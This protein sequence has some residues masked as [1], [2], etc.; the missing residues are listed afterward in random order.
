[1]KKAKGKTPGEWPIVIKRGS[2]TA[3][4]FRTPENGRDRFTVEWYE[5]PARKRLTRVDLAEAR[6]EAK[7]IADTLNAGRG[8]ALELSGADRDAY[9]AAVR[10]LKPLDVPLNVAIAEYVKA[11][12]YNV[13][14]VEAAK[15]Y[16]ESHNA[17]LPD[18]TIEEVYQEMLKAK[19][20]DGASE[21]YLHDLKT[22]LGHFSRDFKDSLANVTTADL[23]AWLRKL[24]LSPCSRNNHRRAVVGLFNFAKAAGYLNRDKKS[25]AE[26]TAVARKTVE[27][28]EVFAPVDFAK[29]LTA[30]DD[31]I[32]PYFVLGGFCGLRTAE[33][34]RLNWEDIRWPEKSIIIDAAISKTRT[35]R[36]AP[37]TDTAA[38]WLAGWRLKTGRVLPIKQP[39]HR[40]KDICKAAGVA[41]KRNGLRHSFITYRL[42][43]VKD[44]MRTAFEA[45]NSPQVIRSNYDAVA[46]EQEGKLWFSVMPETAK[47]VIQMG[48]GAA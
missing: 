14:I 16:A 45:G 47:N 42:A 1:M 18:K 5:G 41:W 11:R 4:I 2:A 8:A 6:A 35:R 34:M 28:I 33:I 32:L 37:L 26:H 7:N 40:V 48:K 25:A 31:V 9:V 15:T 12:Q 20:H 36:L 43:T 27:A 17:K 19:R 10:Q 21:A 30:A 3:K 13:P 44:A 46:T 24:K 23:D 38:A 29:L 39:E 22:R